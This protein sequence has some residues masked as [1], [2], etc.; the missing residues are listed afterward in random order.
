MMKSKLRL[1]GKLSL[2]FLMLAIAG[3]PVVVE[4]STI[5]N[6]PANPS[7]GAFQ[8]HSFHARTTAFTPHIKR[9]SKQGHS[10]LNFLPKNTV[11]L[12]HFAPQ[13][14]KLNFSPCIGHPAVVGSVVRSKS[15]RNFLVL[16]I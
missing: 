5:I 9:Q 4:A 7:F 16:R 6:S 10:K 15:S 12:Y 11:G 14:A 2:C 3:R 13:V 8:A 1:I